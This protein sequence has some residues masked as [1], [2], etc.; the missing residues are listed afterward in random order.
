MYT[1]EFKEQ[2]ILKVLQRGDK[3]IQEI[4]NE[5]NVNLFTLKEWLRKSRSTMTDTTTSKRPA[6]WTRA[7]RFQALMQSSVLNG[8]ALNV[9]CRE[10]GLFTHHLETWKADFIKETS[11]T[12]ISTKSRS[13]KTLRE[14]NEQLRKEL[15]R[16]DKALAEAA[17]LLVL[18]KKFQAFWE[19]KA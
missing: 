15:N 9:F 5:L 4:A 19:E 1:P 18:Q 10:Q 13:E 11:K 12:E 2:A 6:D 14:E 8:E 17:A 3:T 16:K 7:Q